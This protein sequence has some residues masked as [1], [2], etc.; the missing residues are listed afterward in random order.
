[1]T[2]MQILSLDCSDGYLLEPYIKARRRVT[3]KLGL[4]QSHFAECHLFC[5][6]VEF[7]KG[8]LTPAH[9]CSQWFC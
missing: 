6:G 8:T 4:S 5:Y 7:K 2:D 3:S 1:M 9:P